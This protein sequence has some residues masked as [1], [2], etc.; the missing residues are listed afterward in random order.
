MGLE[1]RN[2]RQYYYSKKRVNGRV[3]ST[4]EGKGELADLLADARIAERNEAKEK[5][6]AER[7]VLEIEQE[8]VRRIASLLDEQERFC[9]AIEDA[10]FLGRGYHKHSRTWRKMRGTQI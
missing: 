4:Y 2:G 7:A 10:L 6:E 8:P 9:Q 5:A 3:V 1:T